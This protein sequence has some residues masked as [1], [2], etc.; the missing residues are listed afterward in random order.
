MGGGRE[1]P[2]SLAE[3]ASKTIENGDNKIMMK[4]F[5]AL[6][7]TMVLFLTLAP[8]GV[9]SA[10]DPYTDL[11]AWAKALKLRPIE[12][13][14]RPGQVFPNPPPGFGRLTYFGRAY[15]PTK[16]TPIK[17][18]D[19]SKR[20][21]MAPGKSPTDF[22][23]RSGLGYVA[24]DK[25]HEWASVYSAKAY[26]G[27]Q[28]KEVNFYNLD[29]DHPVNSSRFQQQPGYFTSDEEMVVQPHWLGFKDNNKP[30]IEVGVIALGAYNQTKLVYSYYDPDGV[31]GVTAGSWQ[32]HENVT[33]YQSGGYA[34]YIY[35]SGFSFVAFD[36]GSGF[37]VLRTATFQSQYA[38]FTQNMYVDFGIE[39]SWDEG[40]SNRST[41]GEIYF[42]D[43]HLYSGSSLNAWTS[44][45]GATPSSDP[46]P[47]R[48]AEV[49]GESTRRFKFWSAY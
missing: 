16:D 32:I 11:P 25:T 43:L 4:K 2:H 39:S 38:P 42:R 20:R 22:P 17:L 13:G 36:F 7:L 28:L 46:P 23:D 26:N 33:G 48:V 12:L 19:R 18:P 6:L 8:P 47:L 40:V 21:Y 24:P 34:S 15:E 31:D 29:N 44:S 9:A 27:A 35:S 3:N 41:Y 37:S 45:V 49:T 30:W 10:D 5:V 14:V 1:I